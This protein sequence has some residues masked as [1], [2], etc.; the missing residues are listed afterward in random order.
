MGQTRHINACAREEDRYLLLLFGG[1]VD[2]MFRSA[3]DQ[4]NFEY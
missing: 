4:S 2:E 1:K 3:R